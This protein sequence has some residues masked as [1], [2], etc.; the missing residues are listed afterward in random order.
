VTSETDPGEAF[1]S[2]ASHQLIVLDVIA[3][4]RSAADIC[5]EIRGTASMAA[6]PV[7]CV[8]QSDTVE[9]RIAFFEAGADEVIAKPFDA[10]ELE[11]RVEALLVRFQRSRDLSPSAGST[12]PEVPTGRNRIVAVFSPKGGVGTTTI[13]TNMS[14]V[15]ARQRPER[16][17]LIDLELNFGQIA[18]HLNLD[19]RLSLADIARDETALNEPEILRTYALRHDSG[20]HVLASPPTP[21]L[22]ELVEPSHVTQLLETVVEAYDSVIVDAGSVLDERTM[23]VL[24]RADA[25]VLPVHPEMAALKAVHS[26][27]DYL[28]GIGTVAGKMTFVVNNMFAREI[29]RMRDV[30]SALGTK[31][32]DELLYDPFLYLKAVNEGVPIVLGS[33][34][35]AAADRLTRLT[36][37]V[38]GA[39]AVSPGAAPGPSPTPTPRKPRGLAGILRR[40]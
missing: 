16:V 3:G 38:F 24:E 7:L 25:I 15:Q 37:R 23:I 12:E 34:R 8:A 33:P 17:L 9:E 29:L 26:L 28:N 32:S 35:S 5:R 13:A 22:G 18:T 6:I 21:G 14:L 30:E 1:R 31:V 11:A 40:G 36:E 19:V 39:R 4:D 20:L 2:A 10:R 27:L